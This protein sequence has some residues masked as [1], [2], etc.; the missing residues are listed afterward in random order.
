MSATSQPVASSELDLDPLR[1][2]VTGEVIALGDA[3]GPRLR[4]SSRTMRTTAWARPRVSISTRGW[5]SSS[6]A[7]TLTT[8]SG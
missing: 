1:A 2:Q 4:T 5:S 6:G 8:C 7:S 3:A